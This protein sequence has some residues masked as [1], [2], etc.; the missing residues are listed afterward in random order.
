[1]HVH[2]AG[3]KNGRARVM[4][5]AVG[6]AKPAIAP[7]SSTTMIISLGAELVMEDHMPAV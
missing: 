3:A 7:W 6:F 4:I 5:G 1:M 2:G